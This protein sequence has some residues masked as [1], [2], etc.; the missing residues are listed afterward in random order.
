MHADNCDG[1]LGHYRLVVYNWCADY[2]Q[3]RGTKK[4]GVV[5]VGKVE[6]ITD[7]VCGKFGPILFPQID[8][9]DEC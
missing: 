5:P 2:I 1:E 9:R 3:S 8:N 7:R 6:Y 4:C